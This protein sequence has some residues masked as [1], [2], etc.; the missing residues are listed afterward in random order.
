MLI[1]L[2]VYIHKRLKQQA[3]IRVANKLLL[4]ISQYHQ[5]QLQTLVALSALLRR[6]AI[7]TAPRTDVAALSGSAWLAYLDK[8]FP[9]A[10]FSL[11][12]GRCLANAQYRQTLPADTD[13]DE[14]FKLCARWL[15]LQK[16]PLFVRPAF[17][18][19]WWRK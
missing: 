10:P 4:T 3:A 12:V 8:S 6:V 5:D 9:D 19:N 2:G 16:P 1:I 11:G 15:Q 7:S 17:T 14:L 18:K 13:M